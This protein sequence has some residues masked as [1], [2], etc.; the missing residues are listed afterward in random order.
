MSNFFD[1]RAQVEESALMH[2]KQVQDIVHSK[3]KIEREK[4]QLILQREISKR[5]LDLET[6]FQAQ[7]QIDRQQRAKEKELERIEKIKEKQSDRWYAATF[8]IVGAVIGGLM[9][10]LLDIFFK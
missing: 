10:K 7:K 6:N 3:Q 5:L 4:E 1:I 8:L 2:S 9:V